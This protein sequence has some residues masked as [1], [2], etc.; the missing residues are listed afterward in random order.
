MSAGRSGSGGRC[1]CLGPRPPPC[2]RHPSRPPAPRSNQPVTTT[3]RLGGQNWS[4]LVPD[5]WSNPPGRSRDWSATGWCCAAPA[6]SGSCTG[7]RGGQRPHQRRRVQRR[8]AI[9]RQGGVAMGQGD[10]GATAVGPC[11]PA[12]E[13]APPP[14]ARCPASLATAPSS[15][16]ALGQ[17]SGALPLVRDS[18]RCPRFA[19]QSHVRSLR[20]GQHSTRSAPDGLARRLRHGHVVV[21][22]RRVIHGA[23][24]VLA[25]GGK[26]HLV[27]QRGAQLRGEEGAQRGGGGARRPRRCRRYS[28]TSC[29]AVSA[30]SARWMDAEA[31]P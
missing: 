18:V 6:S 8:L 11:V 5:S 26:L 2:T 15:R 23:Q 1:L 16:G 21:V 13:R 30:P 28:C 22:V 9:A 10:V 4:K 20:D 29:R 25:A 14:A 7:G 3:G 19:K 12:A 27:Q 31:G 24:V 17:P